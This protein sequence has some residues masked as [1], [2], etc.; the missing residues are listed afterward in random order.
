M[1][2]G[3]SAN[4]SLQCEYQP[5]QNTKASCARTSIGIQGGNEVNSANNPE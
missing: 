4:K 5:S 3:I 1:Y 2:C